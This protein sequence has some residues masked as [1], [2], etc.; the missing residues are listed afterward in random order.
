MFTLEGGPCL[1]S[2]SGGSG[3][4]RGELSLSWKFVGGVQPSATPASFEPFIRLTFQYC[5]EFSYEKVPDAHCLKIE[6]L[7]YPFPENE[8]VT[9]TVHHSFLP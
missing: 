7:Y 2:H 6:T 9:L 4:V 8:S 5:T 1:S 3:V